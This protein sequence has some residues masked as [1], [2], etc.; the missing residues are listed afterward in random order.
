MAETFDPNAPVPG[1]AQAVQLEL[2]PLKPAGALA[3]GAENLVPSV[4][5]PGRPAGSKN[6]NTQEWR[7][8]I[9]GR[10]TS[11]LIALGD[12]FTRGVA[13]LAKELGCTKLEAF[14]LQIQA[15]KELAPYVHQKMPI[16]VD[17]GE[18]GLIHLT[19]NHAAATAQMGAAAVPA[20]IEILQEKDEENQ[21]LSEDDFLQSDNENSDKSENA[22]EY[23]EVNSHEQT[24]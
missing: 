4:R 16:A 19:I 7:D 24:D 21:L 2:L 9:L 17:A 10:F 12:T 13:D 6:K 8:Y 14:K 5:G 23:Q 1:D 3:A 20:A 15:A 11:P 22:F 18:G